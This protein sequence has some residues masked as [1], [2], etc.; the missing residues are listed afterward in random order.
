MVREREFLGFNR[1]SSKHKYET[2]KEEIVRK[3]LLGMSC[4]I[5]NLTWLADVYCKI[6]SKFVEKLI[7]VTK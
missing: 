5:L 4:F 2:T 1:F 7:L 6:S 3:L